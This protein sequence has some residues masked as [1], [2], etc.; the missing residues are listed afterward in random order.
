MK[1]KLILLFA[2]TSLVF[3]LIALFLFSLLL[4]R[5]DKSESDRVAVVKEMRALSRL[6]TASFTIEKIIDSESS[7]NV[8]QKLLFGDKILLIANGNVIAGIDFIGIEEKDVVVE[9]KK[10]QVSLPPPQ[11]F[12][13]SL[14]NTK[15]KVYDRKSGL[16]SGGNDNLESEARATAE[17]S[18]REAACSSGILDMAS[19]NARKQITSF[20][21]SLGF[22]EITIT[23]PQGSC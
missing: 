12:L 13:A 14:D 8:F 19:D 22:V 11:I 1:S 20:L 5:T 18:I 6:E 15:T 23:I 10:I 21:S 17:Q 16:L 4:N 9:G 7:G 2:F 3:F